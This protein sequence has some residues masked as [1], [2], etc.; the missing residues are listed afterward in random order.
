MDARY[1]PGGASSHRSQQTTALSDAVRRV[2]ML[3]Q[4][5]PAHSPPHTHAY[6]DELGTPR[7]GYDSESG[8][9]IKKDAT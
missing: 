3:R 5:S 4:L 2:T 6:L 8:S 9:L 1:T 7:Q